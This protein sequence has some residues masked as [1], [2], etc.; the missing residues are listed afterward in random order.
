MANSKA[1]PAHVDWLVDTKRP[2]KTSSG[3]LVT[4]LELQHVGN[5][6][7]LSAWA[8]HFRNHYCSDSEVD[9]L[10]DGTPYSRAEY[11]T[12][13]K[14]PH[15]KTGLG[16]ATR[17]GDFAE[18]LVADYLEFVRDYRVPRTRYNRK[19]ITDESTKG[20]D[21][22][23]FRF[24]SSGAEDSRDELTLFE[25][26]AQLSGGK[27]KPKLQEAVD[28][29]PKDELRWAES[30]NALKQRLIDAGNAADASA[31]RRF[32]NPADRPYRQSY[33]A[34]AVLSS[35]VFDEGDVKM[36]STTAHPHRGSLSLVVIRGPELMALVHALY[37]R[38]AD[39][40]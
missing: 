28:D 39:E 4:V 17:A 25:A 22:V 2:I 30:L 8:R 1:R 11:L 10:R 26:K 32:Q 27:A 16:P 19:T 6:Q 24:H 7:V 20:T 5:A 23:G 34:V 18:I 21:V 3:E 15:A 13:L 12:E 33:G 29:S 9:A 14:F 38:A 40:A 31:V 35:A 37:K 36:V